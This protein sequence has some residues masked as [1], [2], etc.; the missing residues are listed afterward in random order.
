[1]KNKVRYILITPVIY[2]IIQSIILFNGCDST[3]PDTGD[4]TF[5]ATITN[6]KPGF[7]F[8]N[9]KAISLPYNDI[10]PDLFVLAH[11]AEDGSLLGVYFAADSL[12]HAFKRIK[13]FSN[14]DSAESFFNNL[15]EAPDSGYQN[16]ALP[17]NSY[18]V[19]TVKTHDNKYAKILIIYT[20][21]YRDTAAL[22]FHLEATFRWKYQP[23][24]SR[25]F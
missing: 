18:Q 9:G 22:N 14:P 5:I 12:R 2:F 20:E 3:E 19:W 23:D 7:S 16:L 8:S 10:I 21:A 24:G 1:M 6:N 11:I 13:N 4:G 15:S 17:V 25:F